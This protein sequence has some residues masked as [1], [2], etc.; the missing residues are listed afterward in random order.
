VSPVSWPGFAA[1]DQADLVRMTKRRLK[2]IDYG[3][4]DRGLPERRRPEI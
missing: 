3:P 1:A 2:K 4:P